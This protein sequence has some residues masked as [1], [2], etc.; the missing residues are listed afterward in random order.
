M[1]QG[2]DTFEWKTS[3]LDVAM[4]ITKY[5]FNTVHNTLTCDTSVHGTRTSSVWLENFNTTCFY[6]YHIQYK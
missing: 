6:A 2:L 4:H 1:A 3:V 5:N